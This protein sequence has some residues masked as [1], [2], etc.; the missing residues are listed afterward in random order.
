[1]EKPQNVNRVLLTIGKYVIEQEP[2]DKISIT[3]MGDESTILY[4]YH[5]IKRAKIFNLDLLNITK[6][7]FKAMKKLYKVIN[8]P[9]NHKHIKYIRFNPRNYE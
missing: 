4:K 9:S 8:L 6:A 1:M 5:P 2:G 7:D 3:Q